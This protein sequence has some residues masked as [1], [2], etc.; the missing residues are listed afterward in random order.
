M[1]TK[2]FNSAEYAGLCGSCVWNVEKYED[3]NKIKEWA[4]N[5]E[6]MYPEFKCKLTLVTFEGDEKRP[7]LY[8]DGT[9]FERMMLIEWIERMR[10]SSS[11]QESV[12][13]FTS[14]ER[15]VRGYEMSYAIKTARNRIKDSG[16]KYVLDDSGNTTMPGGI[17]ALTTQK[18]TMYEINRIVDYIHRL[19]SDDFHRRRF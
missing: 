16:F 5:F 3:H 2:T 7:S 12:R 17:D 10:Q 1:E 6:L 13:F 8:I 9:A 4:R 14:A 15:N 18:F 11:Y 19:A